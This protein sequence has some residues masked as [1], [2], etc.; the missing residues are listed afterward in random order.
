MKKNELSD[1]ENTS[2]TFSLWEIHSFV[3]QAVLIVTIVI[4]KELFF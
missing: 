2:R 1:T 3:R 4:P